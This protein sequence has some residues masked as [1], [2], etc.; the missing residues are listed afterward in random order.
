MI[1]RSFCLLFFLHMVLLDVFGQTLLVDSQRDFDRLGIVVDSL[2]N[3]LSAEMVTVRLKE[4]VYYYD[5]NHILLKSSSLPGV[6]LTF[7]GNGSTLIGREA[8]SVVPGIGNSYLDRASLSL[9]NVLTPVKKAGF[10]PIPVLSRKGV[11]KLRARNESD[12]SENDAKGMKLVLS[13]WFIGAVYDVVKI[14]NGFIYFKYVPYRTRLWSEFRFGR[15]K[16][17]YFLFRP[18]DTEELYPCGAS[19]F[20][21]IEDSVLGCVTL[22]GIRFLGNRAGEELLRFHSVKADSVVIR[23][24][25]FEGIRSRGILVSGTDRFRLR[26]SVFKQGFLNQVF[27][28]KDSDDA[29]IESN[30]FEDNGLMMTNDPVVDCKGSGFSIRSNL[31]QNYS[32]AAIGLGLH[33]TD[34]SGWITSGVVE[35]NEIRM[36][37]TYRKAPMLSLIDGGGIYIWTQ[38]KNV[39]IRNNYIHDLSGPH[40]NRGIFGDDGVINLEVCGNTVLRV[41]GGYAID[42]RRADRVGRKRGSFVKRTNT[43][44]RVHDNLYS[45]RVRIHVRKDDPQSYCSNNRK[46]D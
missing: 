36:T 38:N 34:P 9:R 46:L 18:A 16:P 21:T 12:V 13:Q 40:G 35:E 25:V 42:I 44:I 4:G 20:L 39:A 43:G 26:N 6:K 29:I 45:G 2:V 22:D 19:N 33:F 3:N 15:C 31:F 17:R 10:W 14:S 5:E 41:D 27:V 11:Y 30:C 37:E 1:H 23:D 32:Y 28:D 8:P 24:C 7:S